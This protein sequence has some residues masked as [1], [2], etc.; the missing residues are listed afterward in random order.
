MTRIYLITRSWLNTH[1]QSI[2]MMAKYD[3]IID[4]YLYHR[5]L[6]KIVNERSTHNQHIF[7]HYDYRFFP[8][9]VYNIRVITPLY[10]Y[11]QEILKCWQQGW[12]SELERGIPT[13]IKWPSRHEIDIESESETSEE[14]GEMATTF[15]TLDWVTYICSCG[16][17]SS[18]SR[19]YFCR[20]CLKLRCGDCVCH[21][22]SAFQDILRQENERNIVAESLPVLKIDGL[23]ICQNIWQAVVE[24]HD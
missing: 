18:L 6:T 4:R 13:K 2:L 22:V 11:S 17:K 15:G 16:A 23:A 3:K 5:S 19:L 21:E 24:I 7:I 20:H 12:K 10:M 1:Y 14:I 9:H 8:T